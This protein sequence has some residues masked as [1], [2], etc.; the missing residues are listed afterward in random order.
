[1]CESSFSDWALSRL[2]SSLAPLL[3][4]DKRALN[5]QRKE[6]GADLLLPLGEGMRISASFDDVTH[7]Y[8]T[9]A[10]SVLS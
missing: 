4:G 3:K 2:D 5:F 10:A 6:R 9:P 1:V 7:F 8:I